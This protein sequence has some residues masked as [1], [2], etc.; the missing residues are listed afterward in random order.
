MPIIQNFDKNCKK[1]P[2]FIYRIAVQGSKFPS[3][4]VLFGLSTA[5]IEGGG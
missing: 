4:T 5:S 2:P 1:T 3:A